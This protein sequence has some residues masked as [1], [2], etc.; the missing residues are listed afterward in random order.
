MVNL[1]VFIP[2]RLQTLDN[3]IF[4]IHAAFSFQA[5]FILKIDESL[6]NT[7]SSNTETLELH[8]SYSSYFLPF[9]D[10]LSPP[11]SLPPSIPSPL[12]PSYSASHSLLPK[13]TFL[14]FP[15]FPLPILFSLIPFF[16][17]LPSSLKT[18]SFPSTSIPYPFSFKTSLSTSISTLPLFLPPSLLPLHFSTTQ[19]YTKTSQK[20]FTYIVIHV[21]YI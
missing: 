12:S 9:S 14:L 18:S 4:S 15:P 3:Y 5:L 13:N 19:L 17:P 21:M 16:R 2:L 20:L 10:P 1:V 7:V 6:W 11:P 8:Y